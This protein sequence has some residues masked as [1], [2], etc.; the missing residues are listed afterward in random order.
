MSRSRGQH[1]KNYYGPKKTIKDLTKKR[2]RAMEREAIT[3][4][5]KDGK[6]VVLPR[7]K[8]CEDIWFYD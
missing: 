6:D 1:K 4:F 5:V 8:D 7:Y 2:S 3:K